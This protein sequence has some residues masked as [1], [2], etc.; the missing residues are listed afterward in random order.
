MTRKRFIK[1]LMANGFCRNDAEKA[2]A[3]FRENCR[4]YNALSPV[5]AGRAIITEAGV[6]KSRGFAVV[7][8]I[9]CIQIPFNCNGE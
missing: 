4:P 5:Y 2:A 6:V 1:Q 3:C 9:P 8:R 7:C